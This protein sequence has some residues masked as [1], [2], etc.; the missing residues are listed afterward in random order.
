MRQILSLESPR[1]ASHQLPGLLRWRRGFAYHSLRGM[2]LRR[3]A[4]DAPAASLNLWLHGILSGIG[5][6]LRPIAVSIVHFSFTCC[7]WLHEENH[8]GSD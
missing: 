5:E 8:E 4:S 7:R 3:G 1:K 6:V 2:S